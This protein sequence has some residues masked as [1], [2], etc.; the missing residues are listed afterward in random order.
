[1]I[2]CV[3]RL[4]TY[5]L[6]NIQVYNPAQLTA[7]HSLNPP[8]RVITQLEIHIRLGN[9]P[10]SPTTLGASLLSA[11]QQSQ[12]CS[13]SRSRVLNSKFCSVLSRCRALCSA[14]VSP[15]KLSPP[16][17]LH[18]KR[19]QLV[20]PC[21]TQKTEPSTFRWTRRETEGSQGKRK[22]DFVGSEKIRESGKTEAFSRILYGLPSILNASIN[23][24]KLFV[25]LI[26][27]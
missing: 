18:G 8:K 10:V 6:S 4:K 14:P 27:T 25:S 16:W 21:F 26:F 23:S 22:K 3:R 2:V 5:S 17:S 7:P 1:M 15:P 9:S 12:V 19:E 20:G 24:T 11:E 13:Q